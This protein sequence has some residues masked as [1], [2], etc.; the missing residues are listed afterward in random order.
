L[1]NIAL[2]GAGLIVDGIVGPATWHALPGDPDTPVLARGAS[3]SAVTALQQGLKK[4]STPAT[5]PGLVDGDFGPKTEA[6]VK[7]YQQDRG[8][9]VDGIVGDN[10]VGARRG[11]GCYSRFAFGTYDS[12]I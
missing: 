6:A 7:A 5:D 8:I 12:M 4:Y 11:C 1:S 3:G 10:V 9:E 2:E